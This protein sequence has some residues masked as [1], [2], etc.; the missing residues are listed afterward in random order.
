MEP[1][2]TYFE[3]Q[4]LEIEQ[5]RN[6]LLREQNELLRQQNK[7]F[8][9]MGATVG[10]LNT[11]AEF[12]SLAIINKTV[13]RFVYPLEAYSTFNWD[14]FG[15]TIQKSDRSG[16]AIVIWRGETYTRRS[17]DKNGKDVWFSRLLGTTEGGKHLYDVLI[18]FSERH[19]QVRSLPDEVK[20]AAGITA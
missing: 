5:E 9:R 3:E 11:I 10:K 14:E 17:F 18:K 15:A 19:G 1:Q 20:E 12:L 8:A 6:E 16:P 4:R 2:L 7:L 13:C